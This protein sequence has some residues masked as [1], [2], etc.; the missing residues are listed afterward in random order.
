MKHA[1]KPP[2]ADNL[3]DATVEEMRRIAE[4]LAKRADESSG[5]K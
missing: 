2:S 3:A 1:L 5:Q 4:E